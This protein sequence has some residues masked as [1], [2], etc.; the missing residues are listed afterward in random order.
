MEFVGIVDGRHKI[1]W[2]SKELLDH[3]RG[4]GGYESSGPLL[5]GINYSQDC[6]SFQGTT[7]GLKKEVTMHILF[8]L[9]RVCA[10]FVFLIP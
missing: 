7:K 10:S 4:C 5:P 8:P 9:R 3:R 2:K 1:L 6:V